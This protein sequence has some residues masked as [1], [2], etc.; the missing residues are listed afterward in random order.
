MLCAAAGMQSRSE[1]LRALAF[2]RPPAACGSRRSAQLNGR[3]GREMTR[4]MSAPAAA[5]SAML[6]KRLPSGPARLATR[7][8]SPAFRITWQRRANVSGRMAVLTDQGLK[9]DSAKTC[10]QVHCIDIHARQHRVC[11]PWQA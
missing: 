5:P 1:E 3:V 10:V 4:P 7:K 2:T 9:R 11:E 8:P 6:L